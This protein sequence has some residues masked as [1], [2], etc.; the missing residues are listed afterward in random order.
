MLPRL[1]LICPS[2]SFRYLA[3][4]PSLDIFT[5][6]PLLSV[7]GGVAFSFLFAVGI[8]YQRELT[9]VFFLH[10]ACKAR[11]ATTT[12]LCRQWL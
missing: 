8:L 3:P 12:V 6:L 5:S 2:L 10:T 1:F 4:R 7:D 9:A 11:T